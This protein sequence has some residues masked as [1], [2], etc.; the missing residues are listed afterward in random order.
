MIW[1]ICSGILIVFYLTFGYLI[2]NIL[3][4]KKKKLIFR[5][6]AFVPKVF[7]ILV[8]FMLIPLFITSIHY[9]FFNS[10]KKLEIKNV[11]DI[12]SIS[13]V[14]NIYYYKLG[15]FS[16]A[17]E[18]RIIVETKYDDYLGT[19]NQTML[20]LLDGVGIVNEKFIPQEINDISGLI[21]FMV[22]GCW[23]LALILSFLVMDKN[24]V[25]FVIGFIAIFIYGMLIS[26][27]VPNIENVMTTA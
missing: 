19:C 14:E 20:E 23:V 2:F 26:F 6:F 24:N 25:I 9:K 17:D 22:I 13:N 12:Q 21:L 18:Y 7:L 27:L 3:Y 15:F 16:D 4:N 5:I 1:E 11:N 10:Y 8:A